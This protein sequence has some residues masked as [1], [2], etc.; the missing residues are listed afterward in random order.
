MTPTEETYHFRGKVGLSW[1]RYISNLR[2]LVREYMK[3]VAQGNSCKNDITIRVMSTMNTAANCTITETTRE[4]SAI[5][6]E[7]SEYLFDKNTKIFC[8]Y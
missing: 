6:K 5:L 4:A 3:R 1:E 2:L 7:W 8:P